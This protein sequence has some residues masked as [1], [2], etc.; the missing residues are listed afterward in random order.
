MPATAVHPLPAP[1]AATPRTPPLS[2]PEAFADHVIGQAKEPA[3]TRRDITMRPFD[4]AVGVQ[5]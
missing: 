4:D 5:Q 2:G 1:P 3:G